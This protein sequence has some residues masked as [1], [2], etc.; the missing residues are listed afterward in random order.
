MSFYED[1]LIVFTDLFPTV[2]S[3]WFIFSGSCQP[4]V[5]QRSLVSISGYNPFSTAVPFCGQT[6]QILSSLS[7]KNGTGVVKDLSSFKFEVVC[8]LKTGLES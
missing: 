1:G 3:Y 4:I 5:F 6:T 8:P 2:A 7:P